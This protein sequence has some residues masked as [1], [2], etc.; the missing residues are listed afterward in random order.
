MKRS[1]KQFL[2]LETLE[3][4]VVPAFDFFYNPANDAWTLTQVQDNGDTTITI[5]GGNNLIVDEA[6]PAASPAVTVGVAFGTVNINMLS[7]TGDDVTVT[8]SAPLFG[9]LNINL[10]NGDGK[11]LTLNGTMN[12]VFG[13]SRI[14]AGTGDQS[15]ELSEAASYD[16]G[17]SLSVDLGLG[18]DTVTADFG[19][20]VGS[21]LTMY[22]VNDFSP[23]PAAAQALTIGSNFIFNPS[24]DNIEND[25][26]FSNANLTVV[27]GGSL[28][29]YGG[30]DEDDINFTSDIIVGRNVSVTLGNDISG[31][32]QTLAFGD[33][34]IG[35]N[36]TVRGGTISG[37]DSVTS[38][39]TTPITDEFTVG[40]NIY[41]NT[42]SIGD[43]GDTITLLG[44]IG[45]RSVSLITG[46]G[47]DSVT[48]SM[49]GNR[50][51]VFASLSL[52]D[53]EFT[54]GAGS[55]LGY[56]YVDFGF[57]SD[58]FTNMFGAPFT[59]PVYLRNLP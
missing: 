19:A 42:G 58:V 23:A 35:A 9:D 6:L 27:V 25:L 55:D 3:D 11:D 41:I 13:N 37:D 8:L 12:M 43:T 49:T 24:R 1:T 16:V 18:D 39:S 40:G 34:T 44:A 21:N 14:T 59:F 31:N 38:T 7:N 17:G 29:Y 50:P 57:G 2:N 30:N 5:D 56:L 15:V 33:S 20:S 47:D 45:G 46:L 10:G 53:D 36:V 48:Y 52:G 28:S 32:T 4:R 54:L 51:R 26:D 22:N